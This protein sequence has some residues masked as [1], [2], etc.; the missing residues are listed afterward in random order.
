M[1]GSKSEYDMTNSSHRNKNLSEKFDKENVKYDFD[2][3][4][5]EVESGSE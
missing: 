5:E 4:S 3:V 2:A 1:R